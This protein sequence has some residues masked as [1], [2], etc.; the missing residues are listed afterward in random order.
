MLPS[1]LDSHVGKTL[2]NFM[3]SFKSFEVYVLVKNEC[4]RRLYVNVLLTS[5]TFSVFLFL[6]VFSAGRCVQ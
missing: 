6:T 5:S 3:F 4:V 2:R 1:V